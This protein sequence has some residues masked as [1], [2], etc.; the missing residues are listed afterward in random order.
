MVRSSLC[1]IYMYISRVPSLAGVNLHSDSMPS[2]IGRK[3]SIKQYVQRW[4]FFFSSPGVK[5]PVF[6]FSKGYFFSLQHVA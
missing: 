6:T 1:Y 2:L 4:G 3:K 5:V